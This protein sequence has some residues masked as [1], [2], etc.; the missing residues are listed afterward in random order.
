MFYIFHSSHSL[1]KLQFYYFI[2]FSVLS[3]SK[4]TEMPGPPSKK[5]VAKRSKKGKKS[6]SIIQGQS[7]GKYN[8]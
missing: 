8:P 2:P 4:G 5:R 3:Q 6:T 7:K 1:C